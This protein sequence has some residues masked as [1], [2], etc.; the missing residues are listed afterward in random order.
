MVLGRQKWMGKRKGVGKVGL[1]S[2]F[3]GFLETTSKPTLAASQH[4][5]EG[6]CREKLNACG[7]RS[8]GRSFP[9]R[10]LPGPSGPAWPGPVAARF[11]AKPK[12]TLPRVLLWL[13][14]GVGGACGLGSAGRAQSAPPGLASSGFGKVSG[15]I[16][17]HQRLKALPGVP[18]E[19]ATLDRRRLGLDLSNPEM[20]NVAVYFATPLT[21]EEI[22]ELEGQGVVLHVNSWVPAVAG[23]H[24]WGFYLGRAEYDAIAQVQRD[25][26]VRRVESTEF[27]LRFHNDRASEIVGARALQQA[28]DGPGLG[29]AGVK[30]AIA[31]TGLDANHADLPTPVEAFDLTDGVD[32]SSWGKDVTDVVN[33]H[34]THV[35]GIAV[36]SGLLSAGRYRGAAPEADLYFYKVGPDDTP[37]IDGVDVIE[38]IGRASAM[39]CDILSLS[40][41]GFDLFQDGTGPLC[42]A[43][44]AAT[45]NGLLTFV[46]AGNDGDAALHARFDL[47]PGEIR[48]RLGMN[49]LSDFDDGEFDLFTVETLRVVWQGLPELGQI[50]LEAEDL[51]LDG[52]LQL[53]FMDESPRGTRVA[54]YTLL[55]NFS[56]A[57]SPAIELNLL[58][59]GVCTSTTV[60][61]FNTGLFSI[62][63]FE[64]AEPLSTVSSPALADTAV[65]V[66]AWTTRVEWTNV[67]G[68]TIRTKDAFPD[69]PLLLGAIA[70][71]S[72]RGPRIDGL[73]KP[74]LVAPGAWTVSCR[75]SVGTGIEVSLGAATEIDDVAVVDNDGE[76]LDGSGPADYLVLSGTSMSAPIAAGT[77][78]LLLEAH[79]NLDTNALLSTLLRTASKA[80]Q[81]DPHVGH[82]LLDAEAALVLAAAGPK[83]SCE[84]MSTGAPDCDKNGRP[85]PCDIAE[86]RLSDCDDS[87]IPDVCEL[88]A[89]LL[90]DCNQN[91]LPDLCELAVGEAFDCNDNGRLDACDLASAAQ[92]TETLF[93]SGAGPFALEVQ[94][95]DGDDLPDLVSADREDRTITLFLQEAPGLFGI[96]L[97]RRL[98]DLP[99]ALAAADVDFDGDMDLVVAVADS[100]GRSATSELA[101]LTNDGKATF[102][103]VERFEHLSSHVVDLAVVD[104][105]DNELPEFVVLNRNP[106]TLTV[107]LNFD[108]LPGPAKTYSVPTAPV[109][110][111]VADVNSD[112]AL[113]LVVATPSTLH[114]LEGNSTGR[115]PKTT[116]VPLQGGEVGGLA[117]G[118]ASGNGSPDAF[119]A[120]APCANV[121][122]LR[123]SNGGFEP[124]E[125]IA[126]P[127]PATDIRL[128]DF[129]R[130]GTLDLLFASPAGESLHVVPS[131]LSLQPTREQSFPLPGSPETLLAHDLNGDSRPE[132]IA[133]LPEQ[134]SIA[135]LSLDSSLSAGLDCNDNGVLDA[136]ESAAAL[137]KCVPPRVPF[138][139]GDANQSGDADI[140]D[141]VAIFNHLFLGGDRLSCLEA[142]DIDNDGE[143]VI[144]D[145]VFLLNFLFLGGAEPAAPSRTSG[146]CDTDPDPPGS[147]GD[148]GCD[149]FSSC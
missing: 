113:D 75:D 10:S 2:L 76:D 37:F 96:G 54:Q 32:P 83:P 79:P 45:E 15:R 5:V 101:L 114:I 35:T 120:L 134:D 72:S 38:A 24:P 71:F 122:V 90:R 136:C 89:G 127:S 74:Q 129:D 65:A 123:G 6:R 142:A 22:R 91:G 7:T 30:F 132:L 44:D 139:R 135:L 63:E 73:P 16:H 70:P 125:A 146:G 1:R 137:A 105:D 94:D 106:A 55:G 39:E 28:P 21:Q 11:A 147:A 53:D 149:A 20:E 112:G 31:D 66:G 9:R 128:F 46:S 87:G 56:T 59:D 145:G 19:N 36:G 111:S 34:G 3:R 62:G 124:V 29:G 140:S 99:E 148:L 67:H 43:V 50:R 12:P 88:K 109:A 14:L 117:L 82:G 119:L 68:E 133:T 47:G 116:S 8:S 141:G 61:I 86:G 13:A 143:I 97:V 40:L 17:Y 77:A 18:G 104:L 85:D 60:H 48:S 52:S 93:P 92:V 103:D 107:Y 69:S 130:D 51:G 57:N 4:A 102:R 42:Q 98:E 80:E 27:L 115:F 126:V 41:G 95:L 23:R 110:V 138:A 118:D 121:A 144:T 78:A 26:R 58:H 131:P 49:F 64:N 25:P 33:G 84:D 108:G 81:P 100:P